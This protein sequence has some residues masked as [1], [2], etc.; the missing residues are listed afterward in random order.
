MKEKVWRKRSR[1]NILIYYHH[2][3]ESINGTSPNLGL[4]V[5]SASCFTSTLSGN[6]CRFS[7]RIVRLEDFTAGV[8]DDENGNSK[9]VRRQRTIRLAIILFHFIPRVCTK[10]FHPAFVAPYGEEEEEVCKFVVL[11]PKCWPVN[12]GKRSLGST[13]CSR[14]QGRREAESRCAEEAP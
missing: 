3:D 11:G 7:R 10:L 4:R 5:R 9:L 8:K 14:G 13:I 6:C 1:K 2:A 12:G